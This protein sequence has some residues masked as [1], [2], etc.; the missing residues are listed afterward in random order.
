M[1]VA[2]W[3]LELTCNGPYM[4]ILSTPIVMKE[5]IISWIHH[6]LAKKVEAMDNTTKWT[7]SL[8]MDPYN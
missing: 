8:I 2:K 6:T 1:W 7:I 5:T 3:A 4:V